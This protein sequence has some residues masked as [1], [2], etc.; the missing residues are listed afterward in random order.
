MQYQN[1]TGAIVILGCYLK[2]LTSSLGFNSSPTTV[3]ME[4]VPGYGNVAEDVSVGATGFRINDA[5]PGRLTRIAAGTFDFVGMIQ[6]WTENFGAGGRTYTVRLADPRNILDNIPVVIGYNVT[7]QE[8]GNI[9]NVL[10]CFRYYGNP[11][12]LGWTDNGTLYRNIF[13]YLNYTGTLVD[14][15]N[16]K[17]RFNFS[18]GFFEDSGN[19]GTCIPSWYK[20]RGDVLSINEFCSKVSAD[21]GFDYYAYIEPSSYNSASGA[22]NVIQFVHID[23]KA[24]G[25]STQ[26]DDF[27][28][29]SYNSGTLIDYKRGQELRTDPNMVVVNGGPATM[30]VGGNSAAGGGSATI[31]SFWGFTQDGSPLVNSTVNSNKQGIVLLEN[32]NGSGLNNILSNSIFQIPYTKYDITRYSG[33][34]GY[35]P[36]LRVDGNT[37]YVTGYK[38]HENVMRAALYSQPAW[39]AM[40]LRYNPTEAALLG[41]VE[42][43]FTSFGAFSGI[44]N[45]SGEIA[46]AM[47]LSTQSNNFLG[48]VHPY[49]KARIANVYDATRTAVDEYYGRKYIAVVNGYSD[50]F[51]SDWYDN[52]RCPQ[53]L[54]FP[55][56]EYQ[57][58]DSAWSQRQ[59][60]MPSGVSNHELLNNSDH[61]AFHDSRGKLKAFVSY[62]N[63]NSNGN[64]EFPYPID[65]SVISPNAF[66]IEQGGKLCIPASVTQYEKNPLLAIVEVNELIQGEISTTGYDYQAAYYDFLLKMG[67]NHS[68]ITQ[69]ELMSQLGDNSEFGLVPPRPYYLTSTPGNYGLHFPVQFV[70]KN[71]G[72]WVA[73]GHRYGGVNFIQDAD[74]EPSQYGSYDNLVAAGSGTATSSLASSDII[75]NAE[76]T[77]AGLPQFNLG[78]RFGTNANI[79]SLSIQYGQD[80]LTTAYSIRTYS[81]PTQRLTKLLFDKVTKLFHR[82]LYNNKEIIRID[83][84]VSKSELENY[85]GTIFKPSQIGGQQGKANPTVNQNAGGAITINS[86]IAIVPITD[87]SGNVRLY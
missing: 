10:D 61:P 14:L 31:F 56:I 37:A 19:L 69:Y 67:Y 40:M 12:G 13:N 1:V 22:V 60:G 30:W 27:I 46:L 52:N 3:E 7:D 36:G 45:T 34:I 63:Y 78:A 25:V 42:S 29:N 44:V 51:D 18:S 86:N 15:H 49:I 59:T 38:P 16:N 87:P 9:P 17:F 76:L 79:S 2:R 4:L 85:G 66:F 80:G 20:L 64:S 55:E 43:P 32:L 54:Q 50:R 8:Y 26:I 41:I 6:S 5:R 83:K 35:R 73:S 70:N 84:Q 75:D 62:P 47:R 48:E 11:S 72:P 53:T 65:L 58:V 28:T 39:E 82:T 33:G 57:V 81:L 77:I 24:A 68:Y 74:L 23:R 21:F 71:F